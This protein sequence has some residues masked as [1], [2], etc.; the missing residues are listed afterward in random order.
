MNRTDRLLAIVLELQGKGRQRAE[1]LAETFETSKRTIY[2]DIQALCEAGVP[3]MST[4]GRGYALMEGYF[5]PPL[6]FSADEATMLLLGSEVMAQN[7]DAQY[8]AAAESAGRKIAGVLPEPLRAEV[9]QL[10]SSIVFVE[11]GTKSK[12][13]E[14]AKLQLL[15][16]AIM[17]HVTVRFRYQRRHGAE[18]EDS[19]SEREADPYMLAHVGDSWYLTAYCHMRRGIRRFRLERMDDL[20]LLARTFTR[21]AEFDENRSI[22]PEHGDLVARVLFDAEVARWVRESR[23]F[24]VVGEEETPAGL[25]ATLRLRL[26]DDALQWLLGWGRHVR[27]LEPES[28]RQRMAAEARALL[29]HHANEEPVAGERQ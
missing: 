19:L 7:F 13:D 24:F 20:T 25:L 23:S 27:V 9:R 16:R 12:P 4:P 18:D 28:L 5:L 15:R 8:R 21:P 6:S 17:Q 22:K 14:Q 1:D 10:Q 2:R 29:H 11:S 3:L 26:E